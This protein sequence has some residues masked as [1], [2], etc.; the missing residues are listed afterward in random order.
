M[1]AEAKHK[2]DG[3]LSLLKLIAS[4]IVFDNI[5]G[6]KRPTQTAIGSGVRPNGTTGNQLR[7]SGRES[8]PSK[9]RPQNNE[10]IHIGC[11]I[12]VCLNTR[13]LVSPPNQSRPGGTAEIH[14]P[15]RTNQPHARIPS[16]FVAG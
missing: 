8:A 10:P 3:T 2:F 4:A 12:F 5:N 1:L 15:F 13:C 9:H 6:R 14:R 16:H 11:Y 7:S